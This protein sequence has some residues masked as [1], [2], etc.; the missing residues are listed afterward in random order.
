MLQYLYFFGEKYWIRLNNL[1]E[2]E[3]RLAPGRKLLKYLEK[4]T[5][6]NLRLDMERNT[7]CHG[8]RRFFYHAN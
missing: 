6:R 3:E 1:I 8:D 4:K 7:I 2:T 5:E